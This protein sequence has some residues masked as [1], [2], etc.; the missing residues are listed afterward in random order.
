MERD[1]DKPSALPSGVVTFLL[2]DVES[3]THLWRSSSHAAAVMGRHEEILAAAVARHHGVRPIEQGEGDST[4]SAFARAS[5]AIAAAA[6]AQRALAAEAW[7]ADATVRVRMAIHSGEAELRGDGAYGG[8]AIIR[9]ARLRAL[10]HG[11]Q[12]VVSAATAAV[13]GD[14]LPASVTLVPL[15][16]VRLAGF[17]HAERVFQLAHPDL[18]AS[19]A[20]L[21]R[22]SADGLTAWPTALVGRAGERTQVADLLERD[23][24]VTITGVGGAGKTRLAHAVAED[25]A[26]RHPDGIVWVELARLSDEAQVAGSVALACGLRETVGISATDLLARSL[27]DTSIL[28]VLD[29]CEHLLE[30]SARIAETLLRAG[31]HL[32]VLATAREPL[33]VAGEVTWRIPSLGLPAEGERDPER[34]AASDAVR[35]FV[36]RARAARPDFALDA[37]AA[38]A[39]AAICR[40]LDG[41]PLAL[42]LAAARVRTMS[43]ERLAT[44]LDDRFRLLTGGPR[45]AVARQRT[46]LASIEW[47]H[48]LLVEPERVLFRRLGV[49]AAA[50]ELE[51]AEAVG[52]DDDLEAVEVFDLLARLVDKSLVQYVGDRYALLETVRQYALER[53]EAAGELAALRDR[54]LEWCRRRATGWRLDQE[55]ATHTV[56]DAVAAEAP[57]LLAALH[58][59]L[60]GTVAIEILYALAPYWGAR[61][62]Y[63]E[64]RSVT[65][66][67]LASLEEGSVAWLCALAPVAADSVFALAVD[68]MPAARRAVDAGGDALPPV[69]RGWLEHALALNEA[70]LGSPRGQSGQE[71]ASELGRASGNRFLEVVPLLALASSM[72]AHGERDRLHALLPWLDRRVPADAQMRFLLDHALASAASFDGDFTAARA[73]LEPHVT[74]SCTVPI[75][76]QLSLIGL[77]TEDAALSRRAVQTVERSAL[78]AFAH[79][80]TWMRA[81]VPMVESDLEAARAILEHDGSVWLMGT[82]FL[83][84]RCLATE[85]DLTVGDGARAAAHLDEAERR[86]APPFHYFTAAIHLLRAQLA[87][88][89]NEIRE[90]ETR[91]HRALDLA[92]EHGMQIVVVDALETLAV[93]AADVQDQTV[94]GAL[95]GACDE[96]RRRTGYRRR[97]AYLRRDLE[98]ARACISTA[99]PPSLAEALELARRGRGERRR[100]VSG[101]D[102]LTPTELRV[103]ELVATGLPNREI[104]AKLFVS[105][106][107]VKTHLVHVYGKLDVRTRAELATAAT[108]RALAKSATSDAEPPPTR[109]DPSADES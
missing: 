78:G 2:T 14:A 97:P 49:F 23:R 90:A 74:R 87:R 100:P 53:A 108:T 51:A 47:S 31:Q 35:L 9:C 83:R 22:S 70:F 42:E 58:W 76:S 99:S 98:A 81:I 84:A 37:A 106:A 48:D 69:A 52:T 55:F 12:V 25:V 61:S 15:D 43:L 94:A 8:A 45:T 3:S 29:N 93:L 20:P 11:G 91:A 32:R 10:A 92:A 62:A 77:W 18:P 30:A 82:A 54:H 50:F 86:L 89:G 80:V 36:E 13:V 109:R 27:G 7:P 66:R 46:L 107:T 33:G 75:A 26:H 67:V 1:S 63:E 60:Q 64:L 73:C 96:F 5:E 17:D 72:A 56:I 59:S 88:A 21:R 24:L 57:D 79:T 103:V 71:R 101:W 104:A 105:L 6:E 41:L 4:V 16:V 68:W 65:A 95:L 38:P 19:F 28:I 40:R 34:A 44:G 39:V 102:S 85:I